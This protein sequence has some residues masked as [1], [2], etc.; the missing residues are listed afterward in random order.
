MKRIDNSDTR[1][2]FRTLIENDGRI[3]I[4]GVLPME[5]VKKY[6]REWGQLMVCLYLVMA[7]VPSF[8]GQTEKWLF[9]VARLLMKILNIKDVAAS[10]DL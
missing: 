7:V 2:D 10:H 8:K 9:E 5:E 3:V 4:S 1:F 6:G